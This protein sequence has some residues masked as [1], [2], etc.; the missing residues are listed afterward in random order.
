MVRLPSPGRLPVIKGRSADTL[1]TSEIRRIYVPVPFN[2]GNLSW[3]FRMRNVLR[4]VL[5]SEEHKRDVIVSFHY[6]KV[7]FYEK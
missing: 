3:V 7:E 5:D 2:C 1:M 6:S 4:F